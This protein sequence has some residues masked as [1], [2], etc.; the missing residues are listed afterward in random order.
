M[1][2]R[3]LERK[4][5]GG[6]PYSQFKQIFPWDCESARS[7][8]TVPHSAEV[9]Q[10]CR[11]LIGNHRSHTPEHAAPF[12][13]RSISFGKKQSALQ[14]E[15]ILIEVEDTGVPG[16]RNYLILDRLPGK[17]LMP[18]ARA[19][20]QFRI[21]RDGNWLKLLD[22]CGFDPYD[23]LERITPPAERP[24][25]LYPLILL[26]N[27]VSA[28]RKRYDIRKA[29]CYWFAG[30][31]WECTLEMYPEVHHMHMPPKKLLKS[32]VRGNFHTLKHHCVDVHEL[33]AICDKVK[34]TLL[35]LAPGPTKITQ[36]RQPRILDARLRE[37]W[38]P[39]LLRV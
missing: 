39:T 17:N 30:L 34:T 24:I 5:V 14:H 38:L 9:E 36:A 27:A 7:D 22:Q 12:V 29:S 19:N 11:I 32:P 15:F 31:I 28:R 21:S 20:D 37:A 25:P 10:L 13:V 35:N 3:Y 33:Q 16:L 26:A 23:I 4:K 2:T 8:D 18:T 1:S 6:L